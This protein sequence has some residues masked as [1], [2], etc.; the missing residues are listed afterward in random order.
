MPSGKCT[1]HVRI[2]EP[3][4]PPTVIAVYMREAEIQVANA[5]PFTPRV[6]D[7]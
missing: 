3:I 6:A 2:W 1:L 4:Q 7:L 5:S